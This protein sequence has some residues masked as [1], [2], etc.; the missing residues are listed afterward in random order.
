MVWSYVRELWSRL[1]SPNALLLCAIIAAHNNPVESVVRSVLTSNT[2]R[3]VNQNSFCSAKQI[4]SAVSDVGLPGRDTM[5]TN[6]SHAN[7][8]QTIPVVSQT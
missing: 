8:C 6:E 4:S 7:Q 5:I 1:W 2:K 3:N